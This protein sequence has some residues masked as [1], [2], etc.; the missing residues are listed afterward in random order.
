MKPPIWTDSKKIEIVSRKSLPEFAASR[1][2][3]RHWMNAVEALIANPDKAGIV[4]AADRKKAR[5]ARSAIYTAMKEQ[6]RRDLTL[7]THYEASTQQLYF[8]VIPAAPSDKPDSKKIA[9]R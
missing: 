8:W 4:A 6:H 3:S 5:A 2:R 1:R 7:V 9:S